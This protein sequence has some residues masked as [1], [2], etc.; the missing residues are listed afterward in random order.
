[1][2]LIELVD[3]NT[4][5]GKDAAKTEKKATRRRGGSGKAKAPVAAAPAVEAPVTCSPGRRRSN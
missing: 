1:M 3:Y 2:A 5:Y 4:V